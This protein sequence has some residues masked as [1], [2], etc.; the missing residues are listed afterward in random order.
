VT[1]D[2]MNDFNGHFGYYKKLKAINAEREGLINEQAQ[3]KLDMATY[4]SNYTVY[5]TS[6][7]TANDELTQTQQ[8]IASYTQSTLY[9]LQK[10]A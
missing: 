6:V 8:D 7:E 2:L 3:L 9:K 10:A 1:N 5:K 4:R